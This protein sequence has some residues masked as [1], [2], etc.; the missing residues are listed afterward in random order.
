[1]CT[2]FIVPKTPK[3]VSNITLA[4]LCKKLSLG[5]KKPHTHKLYFATG[6][7]ILYNNKNKIIGLRLLFHLS[8]HTHWI[9]SHIARK[10]REYRPESTLHPLTKIWQS[11]K[12]TR[13]SKH[14]RQP[15]DFSPRQ[16]DE[17]VRRSVCAEN[18]GQAYSSGRVLSVPPKPKR[19]HGHLFISR[20][21]Q[22]QRKYSPTWAP[23]IFCQITITI[24]GDKHPR[25]P[26][27]PEPHR[28][29]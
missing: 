27:E 1:M 29:T 21:G 22:L 19:S 11:E 20:N 24:E 3:Q 2:F 15:A 28:D 10:K 12:Q 6:S 4:K 9:Q 17:T 25:Q 7:I 16:S 8:E 18:G 14:I 13:M 5:E 26:P 23:D